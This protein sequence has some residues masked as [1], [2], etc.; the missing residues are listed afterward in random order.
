MKLILLF[1]CIL[2]LN[3]S[4]N[5]KSSQV[6][7]ILSPPI[8]YENGN[9]DVSQILSTTAGLVEPTYVEKIPK[10]LNTPYTGEI[11]E[12]NA[13]IS[14]KFYYNGADKLS[15]IKTV[16]CTQFTSNPN[17]CFKTSQC[18]W[19]GETN[20]CI[21]GTP[22]GPIGN[23][24]RNYF[25]DKPSENWEPMN[26]GSINLYAHDKKFEP[27]LHVTETPDMTKV[28]VANPYN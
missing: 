28:N 16:E 1:I 17:G 12:A 13:R 26:S 24:L 20:S 19:C 25:F 27:L 6:I 15:V 21:K 2:S 9:V 3:Q 8:Q 23:C 5:L 10:N 4:K 7:G 11:A 18:G 14:N 22:Q